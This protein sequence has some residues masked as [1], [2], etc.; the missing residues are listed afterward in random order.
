MKKQNRNIITGTLILFSLILLGSSCVKENYKGKNYFAINWKIVE[1]V[2]V[3]EIGLLAQSPGYIHFNQDG[4]GHLYFEF[5]NDTLDTDFVYVI[6]YFASPWPQDDH[7]E[8]TGESNGPN[9]ITLYNCTLGNKMMYQY[10]TINFSI[11]YIKKKKEMTLLYDE[12]F[13][14]TTPFSHYDGS[15]VYLRCEAE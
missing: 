6:E 15:M 11:E 3:P 13:N 12:M 7:P 10:G 4:T 8:E 14:C 2:G 9:R 5:E 1:A